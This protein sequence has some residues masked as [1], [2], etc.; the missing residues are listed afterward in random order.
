M[1]LLTLAEGF[2][3]FIV[4]FLVKRSN[5]MCFAV[6]RPPECGRFFVLRYLSFGFSFR[7]SALSCMV[8]SCLAV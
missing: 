4:T 6:L 2:S 8:D 3:H 7:F 5:S 1:K